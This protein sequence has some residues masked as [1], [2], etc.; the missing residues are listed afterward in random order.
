MGYGPLRDWLMEEA[1]SAGIARAG[2]AVAITS[3]CQQAL[4]LLQRLLAAPGETV[5]IEDPV[6]PG[7]RNVFA[8]GGVRCA[9]IPMGPSGIDLDMLERTLTRERVR[10][11]V[12]TPNFQNPTGIT[13][14]LA[15]G[16]PWCGWCARPES[17][18]WKTTFMAHCVTLATR[19]RP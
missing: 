14:P 12:V 15:R 2:D 16:R 8:A 6:Y 18:W 19:C 17:P 3:G 9:G 10:L 13:M 7:L 1:L 5:L 11:L 4:D